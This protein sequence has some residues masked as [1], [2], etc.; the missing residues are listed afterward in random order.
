MPQTIEDSIKH[1]KLRYFDQL[2]GL[3]PYEMVKKTILI[4]WY[5][6]TGN[7]LLESKQSVPPS[8]A[9]TKK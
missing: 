7:R 1:Y 6:L 3:P 4:F 8:P 5:G 9:T 2:K